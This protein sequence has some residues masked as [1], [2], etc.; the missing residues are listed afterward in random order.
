MLL[1]DQQAGKAYHSL[2]ACDLTKRPAAAVALLLLSAAQP[3]P[4]PARPRLLNH[5]QQ[6]ACR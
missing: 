4:S 3:T 2:H 5:R 6:Y 1:M